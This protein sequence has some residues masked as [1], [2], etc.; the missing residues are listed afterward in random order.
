S[1][2][3]ATVARL[4]VVPAHDRL[5]RR[6]VD[7]AP[8]ARARVTR[9]LRLL[10]VAALSA[11]TAPVHADDA[12]V[13]VVIVVGAPGDASYAA[14]FAAA[15]SRWQAAANRGGARTS[16]VGLDPARGELDRD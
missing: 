1:A 12:D 4:A 14:P 8:H 9:A 11:S 6:R 15:V 2:H 13:S 10:F 16:V 5:L 3:P 7:V